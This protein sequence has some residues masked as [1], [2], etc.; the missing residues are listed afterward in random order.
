MPDILISENIQGAAVDAL[1]Q[2]FSVTSEPDLWKHPADLLR[3]IP[4]FRALIVRNQTQ[5]T[6]ALLEAGTRLEV[7]GRAGVGLDNVDVKAAT[8]R[9]ILITSTPDQNAISVAELAIGMM[10]SL[11]RCLPAAHQDTRAGNWNRQRFS[12]MELHGKTFGIIGAG[13]IGYLTA[14]RAQAF[15][16]T[17]LAFDPYLSRDNVYLSELDAELVSLEAS[18]RPRRRS[19]LPHAQYA[20]NGRPARRPHVRPHEEVGLLHQHLAR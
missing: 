19:L 5:V 9:G 18:P 8:G 14:R 6:R 20:R 4:D 3:C 12:G 11:A 17:I 10:L 2:R 13:K 1:R 7:V 15:G 16:M